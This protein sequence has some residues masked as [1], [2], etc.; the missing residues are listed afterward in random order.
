[1]DISSFENLLKVAAQQPEPQRMLFVFVQK[2]PP[3]DRSADNAASFRAGSGGTL[4]PVVCV[5]K[6][7]TDIGS[8]A[9]LA[10]ESEATGQRWDIVLVACLA[11][12]NGV[13]PSAS[14]VDRG[15]ETMVDAVKTGD[16]L[17]RFLAFDH[18]GDPM[19]INA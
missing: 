9:G 11:G 12:R 4:T 15:L 10:K 5:D 3:D 16:K 14:E 2:G 8:F 17:W 19:Q 1:M 6:A 13:A 18:R 7:V